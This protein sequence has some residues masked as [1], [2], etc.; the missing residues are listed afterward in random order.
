MNRRGVTLVAV[1]FIIL[2]MTMLVISLSSL[3]YSSSSLAVRGYYSLKTFYIANTGQEYYFKLLSQDLDWS[4][5]PFPETKA[6][7]GG[8][9]SIATSSASKDS[10]VVTVTAVLTAEGTT[11]IRIIR[12]SYGRSIGSGW[13]NYSLYF[14]GT[15]IGD[16]ETDI[17]NNVVINGD[18]FLNSDVDLGSNVDV[19]GDLLATGWIDGSTSEVAGVAS[20]YEATP[21]GFPVLDTTYYDA[22]IASAEA[23]PPLNRTLSGTISG[24]YYVNGN[25]IIGQNSTV[26][27][28]AKFVASGNITIN[29]NVNIGDNTTFISGGTITINN[30]VEIGTGGLFFASIGISINN[31][32]EAGTVTVGGGTTFLTPGYVDINNNCDIAGFIYAGTSVDIGENANFTG[33]II[34]GFLDSIGNNSTITL[35]GTVVDYDA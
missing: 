20:P 4:N 14:A 18:I 33:N 5:P 10:I 32:L 11:Y 17:G 22:E 3:F 15:A 19:N 2:T 6:F 30:N 26:Q 16:D 8:Y 34:G 35:S 1:M 12:P 24:T 13:A 21:E 27:N 25:L 28:N 23:L 9:F 7:N 29:N 31:N